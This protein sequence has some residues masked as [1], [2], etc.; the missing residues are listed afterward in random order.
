MRCGKNIGLCF[1]L[2]VLTCQ[3]LYS[4]TLKGEKFK[5]ISATTIATTLWISGSTP[6]ALGD[7]ALYD[8]YASSYNILDGGRA[9]EI[10]G[11]NALRSLSARDAT[12]DV[13]EVAVGTGLQLDFLDLSNN[14]S[15]NKI[16]SVVGIDLSS[17]MLSEASKKLHQEQGTHE[18]PSKLLQM[19]ASSMEFSDN[20]FDTV[21]STFSFCVFEEPEKVMQEM[22]RVVKPGGKVLL[23]ENS[24][25]TFKPLAIV[26]DLTEPLIT[27]FSK[28]C[29]WN[30]DV[31]KI[32]EEAGLTIQHRV[33]EQAG[34]IFYGVYSKK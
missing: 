31:P 24:I 25:S 13:L 21:Q 1:L 28:N 16:K 15:K 26:Q 23:L 22:K 30:V 29:R 18:V 9:A 14:N 6:A 10:L 5:F 4:W 3:I 17:S 19:D 7:S 32:A 33:E 11:L 20:T 34:T 12:G 27:P 8:F 2:I